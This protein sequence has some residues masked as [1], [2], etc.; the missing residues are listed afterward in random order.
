MGFDFHIHFFLHSQSCIAQVVIAA[1]EEPNSDYSGTTNEVQVGSTQFLR[2]SWPA[3]PSSKVYFFSK[4]GVSPPFAYFN[5]CDLIYVICRLIYVINLP[6]RVCFVS[7]IQQF[8]FSNPMMHSP[9]IVLACPCWRWPVFS[10][11]SSRDII[12]AIFPSLFIIIVILCINISG[13]YKYSKSGFINMFSGT[14]YN[15]PLWSFDLSKVSILI[16]VPQIRRDG[17]Q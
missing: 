2:L 8:C 7:L 14:G 12:D 1:P 13:G 6:P 5:I 4:L 15:F 16:L 10:V 3:T 17:K 9:F 11:L